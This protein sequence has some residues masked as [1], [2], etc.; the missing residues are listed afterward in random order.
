MPSLEA[1]PKV[2]FG[3][4]SWDRASRRLTVRGEPTKIAWRV[5]ECLAILIE[6]RGEVVPKEEF[7][8][9]IWGGAALEDSNLA[10]C[11]TALRRALDP[12]P[13][14]HSHIETVARVGYRLAVAIEEEELPASAVAPV[15]AEAAALDRRLTG[16]HYWACRAYMQLSD[17]TG[18]LHARA[19]EVTSCH[20]ATSADAFREKFAPSLVQGRR[21]GLA[22]AWL[23]EVSAGSAREVHRYN[24]ALWHMW[25]G[26]PDAALAELEAGVA[27][28]PYAM[29]YVAVDPA[30]VSLR[31]SARF[32]E[33][34]RRVGVRKCGDRDVVDPSVGV[35]SIALGR[36][37]EQRRAAG[38]REVE[39]KV[40]P[41]AK[42][43]GQVEFIEAAVDLRPERLFRREARV[44]TP[45]VAGDPIE[46][47]NH[48]SGDILGHGRIQQ[49][50]SARVHD[51]RAAGVSERVEAAPEAVA[52]GSGPSG[53]AG[54]EGTVIDG[55]RRRGQHE[56]CGGE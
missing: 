5:A 48:Q 15:A 53:A 33:V 52:A 16:A 19:M 46:L 2:R 1:T 42:G 41:H 7:H 38:I 56:G 51:K 39:R 49:Q 34:C 27:S 40:L 13:D 18:A 43:C 54:I 44:D 3:A 24:R 47:S 17:E 10:Q 55:S 45:E 26:E 50:I 6:A 21:V 35:R 9:Q 8:R 12:A 20:P 23:E 30:F 37:A 32:R 4:A 22:R 11:V 14:G 29:M 31:K 36:E 28:K 25:I